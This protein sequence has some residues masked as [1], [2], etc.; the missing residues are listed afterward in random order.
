MNWAGILLFAAALALLFVLRRVGLIS[1]RAAREHLKNGALVIDVRTQGEYAAGHLRK[2]IHLPL[3]QIETALPKRVPNKN[4]VLLLHCQGGQRSAMARRQL[5]ALGYTQAF[6]L[7][8][9]ARAA[10]IVNEK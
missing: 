4:T 2:A 3:E 9:M 7:G 6:N 5:Q 8:S 10:R 1:A